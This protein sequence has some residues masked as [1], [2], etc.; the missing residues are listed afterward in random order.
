[1]PPSA[2]AKPTLLAIA[3]PI[4][5]EQTLRILIGTVDTFMVSHVS[6]GAVAALGV[7]HQFVVLA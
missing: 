7:A 6:D 2:A 3:W 1:M 5:I 4:F